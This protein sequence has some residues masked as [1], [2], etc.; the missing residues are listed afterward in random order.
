MI[1]SLYLFPQ[2]AGSDQ[3]PFNDESLRELLC[4]IIDMRKISY[5]EK[6]ILGLATLFLFRFFFTTMAFKETM[7]GD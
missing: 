4:H 7:I 1:V 3:Y 5:C 6:E 2:K